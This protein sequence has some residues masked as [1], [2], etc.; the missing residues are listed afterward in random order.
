MITLQQRRAL[1][2]VINSNF[3]FADLSSKFNGIDSSTGNFFCPFHENYET[4]AAK[5]YWDE[6]R[7]IWVIWCFSERRHFTAYDYVDLILCSKYQKYKSPLDFL[8]Q[9]MSPSEVKKQLKKYEKTVIEYES[10]VYAGKV[11]YINTVSTQCM[12][13]EDY[14]E[15]LYTN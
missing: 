5:M 6:E 7:K 15:K 4:P 13:I 10:N 2:K 12:K 8:N 3:T 9:N 11:D 14:I 1:K